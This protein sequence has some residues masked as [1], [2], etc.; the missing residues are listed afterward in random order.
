MTKKKK[1]KH[2]SSP[3]VLNP[4]GY[5]LGRLEAA[6]GLYQCVCVFLFFCCCFFPVTE[7]ALADG[8]VGSA[9]TG[10]SIKVASQSRL[11]GS[12]FS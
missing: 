3:E 8:Q 7:A 12:F 1:D 2:A 6:M 4:T 11:K 10:C 9:W 5:H